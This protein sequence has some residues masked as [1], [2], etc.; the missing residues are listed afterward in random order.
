[1]VVE[2]GFVSVVVSVEVVVAVSGALVSV[3][4]SVGGGA[5]DVDSVVVMVVVVV[6]GVVVVVVGVVAVVVVVVVVGRSVPD[7]AVEW[8]D[9]CTTANTITA[10]TTS[11]ATAAANTAPDC[12]YHWPSATGN[13]GRASSAPRH[14]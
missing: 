14:N 8:R 10:T 7:G 13:D 12:S 5:V 1:V 11:P 4:G 9:V 2:Y 6:G 3:V